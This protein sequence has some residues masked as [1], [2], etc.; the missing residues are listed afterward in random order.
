MQVTARIYPEDQIFIRY[1]FATELFIGQ[2]EC[3]F[4]C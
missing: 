1:D 3:V 4:A 2:H